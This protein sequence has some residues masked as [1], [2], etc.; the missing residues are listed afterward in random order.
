MMFHLY[1]TGSLPMFC[2]YCRSSW[3][4]LRL[5][6]FTPPS[7]VYSLKMYF[8]VSSTMDPSVLLRSRALS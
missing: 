2:R 6:S 4:L 8:D 7:V 1:A 5:S 3:P